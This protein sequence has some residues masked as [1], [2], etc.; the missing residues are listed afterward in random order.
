MVNYCYTDHKIYGL[1]EFIGMY[2]L[3][4]DYYIIFIYVGQSKFSIS[5]YD[6]HCMNHFRDFDGYF[7]FED[8]TRHSSIVILVKISYSGDG[9]DDSSASSDVSHDSDS[10][11][12]LKTC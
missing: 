10:G 12:Q 2:L 3:Q 4:K 11:M 5:V 9:S 6:S 1:H 8:Y 7:L